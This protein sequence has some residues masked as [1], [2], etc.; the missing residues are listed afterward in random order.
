MIYK[1]LFLATITALATAQTA[2][3]GEQISDSNI[4]YFIFPERCFKDLLSFKITLN[5]IIRIASNG[6]SLGLVVFSLYYKVPQIVKMLG[7]K[8]AKSISPMSVLMEIMAGLCGIAYY[9]Y[10]DY[11]FMAYGEMISGMVQSMI[12][13]FLCYAYKE[14]DLNTG[15][16]Y[17]GLIMS[18]FFGIY[19]K[20]LPIQIVNS[21]LMLSSVI[22]VVS[23]IMLI[24][25]IIRTKSSGSLSFITLFLSMAGILVR[26]LTTLINIGDYKFLLL[27]VCINCFFSSVLFFIALV[28]KKPEKLKAN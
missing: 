9:F 22:Y 4:I 14:L 25:S 24:I 11:N 27:V 7:E 15:M 17:F 21:L 20:L 26:V 6:L 8:S 18:S 12:I 23:R 10:L 28:Y 13:L 1:C 5:C 19:F 3:S 16:I 2:S